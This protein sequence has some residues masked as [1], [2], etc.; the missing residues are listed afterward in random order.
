[1]VTG[2]QSLQFFFYESEVEYMSK[3]FIKKSVDDILIAVILYFYDLNSTKSR[4]S[5]RKLGMVIKSFFNQ[6]L[7][8]YFV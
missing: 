3:A 6:G 4:L 7:Q 5:N 2:I 1:M 8:F